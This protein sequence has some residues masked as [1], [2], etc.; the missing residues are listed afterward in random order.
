LDARFLNPSAV[1]VDSAK[2][3]YVADQINHTIRKVTS[4]GEVTT[5]A[6]L[7]GYGG[8][9]DGAGNEARF[10]NP[11]GVAVDSTGTVYVAD[12]WNCTIRISLGASGGGSIA[13]SNANTVKPPTRIVA[14]P[15]VALGN[16]DGESA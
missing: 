6:G 2:N 14:A 11:S 3:V 12:T 4:A 13:R 10:G 9:A 15:L 1:A 16:S 7:A 8:I 5:L